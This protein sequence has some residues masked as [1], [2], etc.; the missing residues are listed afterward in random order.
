MPDVKVS[1]LGL[2]YGEKT[3]VDDVSFTVL[4]GEF[5]TLLGPSGCGKST[6]LMSIAG[7]TTPNTGSITCGS[8]VLFDREAKTNL[9]PERRNLGV[10]FQSYAI[11]PHKTV[12][13]NVAYPLKLRKVRKDHIREAVSHTLSMVGL[14]TFADRYPYQL[15]GGQQQRVALARAAVGSPGVMLLD[16]PLSNLDAK[17]REQARNWLKKFQEELGMTTIFVTHDQDEALSMSDRIV[18]LNEGKV[19]QIG[20]PEEIYRDPVSPFV[21]SFL[22]SANLLRGVVTGTR[23][24]T[25]EIQVHGTKTTLAVDDRSSL[26]VGDQA[27][28]MIRPEDT[29]FGEEDSA[30][31]TAFNGDITARMFVGQ[32]Y[33]Y[34]VR[35]GD[36]N[37]TV[38]SRERR[39]PGPVRLHVRPGASRLFADDTARD[40]TKEKTHA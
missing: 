24:D 4:D 14:E 23:G 2:D 40:I 35:C 36:Q 12:S 38:A 11:W 29:F 20:T 37:L 33:R 8:T 34:T 19:E 15:S 30:E 1:G 39:E 13:E 7:L 22:G 6:T 5:L 31:G 25:C 17:L 9:P 28:V 32:A 3:A 27:L 10:V 26:G 18:V 21:A 16:E